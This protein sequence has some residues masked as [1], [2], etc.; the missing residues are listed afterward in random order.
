MTRPS[1]IDPADELPIAEV[2]EWSVDLK[3]RLLREYVEATWAARGKYSSRGYVDLFSGP[4]RV[5]I[6]GTDEIMDGSP[7]VAWRASDESNAPYTEIVI[8]DNDRR[9]VEACEARLKREG[10]APRVLV[11][12]AHHTAREGRRFVEKFGLHLVFLDPYNLQSLPF[13]VFEAFF[14]LRH[15]DFIVHLSANDLQR[16]LD[17]YLAEDVSVMDEFAPGWRSHVTM[18]ARDQMRG[19]AFWYWVSLFE[20]CGFHIAREAPLV[21]GG[22]NQPLYW[23]LLLSRHPLAANIWN[24]VADKSPQGKFQF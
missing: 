14:D 4:G 18:R 9:A 12:E 8:A 6:K 15:V 2:G 17:S 24:S 22:K 13:S 19:T 3:H 21:R 23:L 5:R 16:N 7:L 20:E 1:P 11:G 10:S